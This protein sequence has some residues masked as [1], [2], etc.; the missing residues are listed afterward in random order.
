MA[1]TVSN[2]AYKKER[3]GLKLKST[4]KEAKWEELVGIKCD[5]KIT[6]WDDGMRS[7]NFLQQ[8]DSVVLQVRKG[9]ILHSVFKL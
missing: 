4:H 1:I 3:A 2:Q 6:M 7:G 5:R 9:N 8:K